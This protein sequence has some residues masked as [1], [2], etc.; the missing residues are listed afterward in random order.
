M[1]LNTF[2]IFAGA[3]GGILADLILEHKP[4]GAIEIEEYPRK[5]LLERQ[6]DG[7]LPKFPIWDDV[8]TFTTDNPD[9]AGFINFLQKGASELAICGG[10]P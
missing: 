8:R 6:L 7:I 3:G 9:T 4:I 2:H 5:V 1:G 10:F